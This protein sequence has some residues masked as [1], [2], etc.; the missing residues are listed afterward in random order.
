MLHVKAH[1]GRPVREG[2]ELGDGIQLGLMDFHLKTDTIFSFL[3]KKHEMC[4]KMIF[5]Y[6]GLHLLQSV[7]YH[8]CV[9][10]YVFV[11][12]QH[13]EWM[14]ARICVCR[15]RSVSDVFHSLSISH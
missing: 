12:I 10:M 5:F 15:Q 3:K 4:L 6:S 7:L 1:A 8:F 9:S 14:N 2:E 13:M 11:H